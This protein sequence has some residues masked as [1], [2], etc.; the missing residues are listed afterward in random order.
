MLPATGCYTRYTVPLNST[1]TL[2][3]QGTG[4]KSALILVLV[5]ITL[6]GLVL[7]YGYWHAVNHGAA[8]FSLLA[9]NPGAAESDW[10]SAAT[11]R[12]KDRNRNVLAEG[13]RD[14]D[15]DI[16]HLID[17][18]TGGCQEIEKHAA[19]SAEARKSW[20][21]C[22]ARLSAW[23]PTWID[24]VRQVQI[25]H[26][27]CSSTDI[28]L[29]VMASNSEWQLWWVPHPHIGGKPY[30]YYSAIIVVERADCIS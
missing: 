22:F 7:G 20:H 26:E 30:T 1:G 14:D 10:L 8:Y 9:G 17:P 21:E 4:L 6:A 25:V 24:E 18:E 13:I 16:V 3:D 19:Y 12:F 23:I 28:P 27:N 15:L 5:V 29:E 2:D 11:V